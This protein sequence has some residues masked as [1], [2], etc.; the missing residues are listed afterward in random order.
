MGRLFDEQDVSLLGAQAL[1]WRWKLPPDE[2]RELLPA[3]RDAYAEMRAQVGPS[4]SPVLDTLVGRQQTSGFDTIVVEPGLEQPRVGM[5]FLHGYGG[6]FTLECWLVAAAAR[7]VGAVTVCPAVGITG[8]W[9]GHDGERTVQAT[10]DFLHR[11]GV[12]RVYL[13]GLSN[14][15]AGAGTLAP[16]LTSRLVGLIL[17]SGAPSGGVNA[18]VPTLVVHGERDPIASAPAAQAYAARA[19]AEYAGF[20]AGHF[21]L[22]TR[23]GEIRETIARWLRR[24]EGARSGAPLRAPDPIAAPDRA[25]RAAPRA[26]A[27]DGPTRAR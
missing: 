18:G 17:I 16:R 9:S 1:L 23:R 27:A 5:I 3:M 20:D 11:R 7:A 8:H 12:D 25:R 14:G 15:A 26:R 21:A 22:L 2:R 13:A 4:P 19:R 6:S 24:H 10:L